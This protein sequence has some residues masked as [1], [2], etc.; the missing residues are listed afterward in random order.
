MKIIY[1]TDANNN[2]PYLDFYDKLDN[3]YQIVIQK[4]FRRIEQ[5][6][7]LGNVKSVGEGIFELK[8]DNGIRIYFG[9]K[10]DI[11]IIILAGSL[12][13]K[14]QK[15]IDKAKEYWKEYRQNGGKKNV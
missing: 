11:L 5:K 2:I 15:E 3:T 10:D 4:R 6:N 9:R 7:N 8:F 14:Q 12:K 13:D 1:Y